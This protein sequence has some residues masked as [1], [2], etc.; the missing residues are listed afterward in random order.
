MFLEFRIKG[1]SDE[2]IP[3]NLN[4]NLFAYFVMLYAFIYI[5]VL[6]TM[7]C[8][9]IKISNEQKRVQNYLAKIEPEFPMSKLFSLV[10]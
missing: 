1:N 3:I 5:K 8:E 4:R 9:I 10:H 2:N 6:C 7:E